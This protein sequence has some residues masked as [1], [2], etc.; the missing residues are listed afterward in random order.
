MT[1]PY[2]TI[3]S[4]ADV[5]PRYAF[6]RESVVINKRRFLREMEQWLTQ[7][8]EHQPLL[9]THVNANITSSD[10]RTVLYTPR[11]DL[12]GSVVCHLGE[13]HLGA[14]AQGEIQRALT[15]SAT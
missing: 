1:G 12:G 7:P 14:S 5:L 4:L 6:F 8:E 3:A 9:C 11:S 15:V 2:H 10:T 13:A